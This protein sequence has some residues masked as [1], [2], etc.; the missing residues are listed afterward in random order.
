MSG[1]GPRRLDPRA[2]DRR[3]LRRLGFQ[4]ATATALGLG[5]GAFSVFWYGIAAHAAV[6]SLWALLVILGLS[7]LW[8]GIAVLLV[9]I[10]TGVAAIGG[11]VL[12]VLLI[13]VGTPRVVTASRCL[14]V[15]E[16]A[17]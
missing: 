2:H 5:P 11:L 1:D 16:C 10:V 3:A 6:E 15:A 14:L 4:H 12:Y 17:S 7:P 9:K 13:D 8:L